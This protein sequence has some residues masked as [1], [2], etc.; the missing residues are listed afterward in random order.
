MNITKPLPMMCLSTVVLF[1]LTAHPQGPR[2]GPLL[3]A[4]PATVLLSVLLVA[5]QAEHSDVNAQMKQEV[6]QTVHDIGNAWAHHD[7]PTL[8]RL[9]ADDYTHTDI[10]GLVQNRGEWLADV[11]SR[12]AS[13]QVAHDLAFEDLNVQIHGNVAVVTGRNIW[14]LARFIALPLRFTQVLTKNKGYWQRSVFQAGVAEL[15][16][17]LFVIIVAVATSSVLITWTLLRVRPKL[18]PRSR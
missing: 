13:E 11:R 14:R 1:S 2:R 16:R 3:R 15:P 17:Y 4:P 18:L 6:I 12:A 5:D 8:E 10:L 7:L 9:V